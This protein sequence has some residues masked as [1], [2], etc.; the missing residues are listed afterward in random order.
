MEADILI[1]ANQAIKNT[2]LPEHNG[3]PP[4]VIGIKKLPSGAFFLEMDSKSSADLL[5]QT[6]LAPN[7]M[8]NFSDTSIIKVNNYS[9]I[10]EFTLTTFNLTSQEDLA[11][12]EAA[13]SLLPGDIATA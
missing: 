1:R 2:A 13:N 7:F 9:I 12:V 4:K 5:Q 8:K 6:P 3:P 11:K 10:V